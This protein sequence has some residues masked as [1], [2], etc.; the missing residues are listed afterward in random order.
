V[1]PTPPVQPSGGTPATPVVTP[2]GN[3]DPGCTF[4]GAECHGGCSTSGRCVWHPSEQRCICPAFFDADCN[5]AIVSC[6]GGLCFGPAQVCRPLPQPS[7]Q[8]CGCVSATPTP[9]P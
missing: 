9:A 5:H 1:T 7:G 3:H 4:D 6:G 8:L 2:G